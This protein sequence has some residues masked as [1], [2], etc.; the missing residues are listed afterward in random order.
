VRVVTD[1]NSAG[2]KNSVLPVATSTVRMGWCLRER[3]VGL[4][5]GVATELQLLKDVDRGKKVRGRVPCSG[6]YVA[7]REA[8][9]GPRMMSQSGDQAGMITRT[10]GNRF[11]GAG[12]GLD[13]SWM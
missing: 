13:V 6:G 11:V 8:R 5:D 3:G 4:V 2:A 7:R 9:S 10:L 1:S 12:V